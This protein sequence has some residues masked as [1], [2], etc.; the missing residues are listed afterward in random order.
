MSKEVYVAGPLFNKM[1]N[2]HNAI[3]TALLEDA[4]YSVFNPIRDGVESA[5]SFDSMDDDV[6]C[7]QIYQIDVRA[8]QE[9]R[10]FIA[11]LDGIQVDD[12]TAFEIG[13]AAAQFPDTKLMIAHLTDTRMNVPP[14][15]RNPMVYQPFLYSPNRIFDNRAAIVSYCQEFDTKGVT[16]GTSKA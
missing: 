10:I 3:L 11:N 13:Y 5:A 12:G 9:C 16:V 8:I 1:E 6:L 15:P 4:G 7:E 14:F 2:E